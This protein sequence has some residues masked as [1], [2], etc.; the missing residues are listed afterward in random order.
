MSYYLLTENL[1]ANVWRSILDG[2]MNLHPY[3]DIEVLRKG[4]EKLFGGKLL[5]VWMSCEKCEMLSI[6]EVPSIIDAAAMTMLNMARGNTTPIHITPLL[7]PEE[8]TKAVSIVAS[9][10][11]DA[12]EEG[13]AIKKS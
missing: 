7:A 3:N 6:I 12:E 11:K 5:N 10:L 1:P 13:Y 9:F 8:A 4:I 2:T